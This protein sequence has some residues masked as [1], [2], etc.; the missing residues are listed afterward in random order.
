MTT[1]F[2][3]T[4]EP[5]SDLKV[6]FL[7]RRLHPSLQ[8]V[9]GRRYA[10][11]QDERDRT[12]RVIGHGAS[13]VLT[14]RTSPSDEKVAC[15]PF[16]CSGMA[17]AVARRGRH[18]RG[19]RSNRRPLLVQI[20]KARVRLLGRNRHERDFDRLPVRGAGD[21]HGDEVR[22]RHQSEYAK[23]LGGGRE[24]VI[25]NLAIPSSI[26]LRATEVID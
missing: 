13:L 17:L 6:S 22:I 16:G 8:S 3:M 18:G 15:L 23:A 12:S 14:N 7:N 11:R 5:V 9:P 1:V 20:S 24:T 10:H 25:R 26:L 2:S 19:R 21:R 4:R